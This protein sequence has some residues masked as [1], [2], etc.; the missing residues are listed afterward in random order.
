MRYEYTT[1]LTCEEMADLVARVRDLVPARSARCRP[2]A[3]GLFK[4]VAVVLTLMRQ[5]LVQGVVAD[6]FHVSQPTV[7]RI[8]RSMRGYL[9][10]ALEGTGISLAQ[11]VASR[12]LLVDG[13]YVRTGN[14]RASGKELYSGKRGCQCVSVQ[15]ACDL[16]GRLIT[17][18]APVPGVRHDRRAL[19]LVRW[20]QILDSGTWIADAGYVGTSAIT[21]I[22]KKPGGDLSADQVVFNH[23]ISRM[24][25][26]VERCIAHLK[27]WKMMKTG[28]RGRLA[29][30]PAAITLATKLELFRLGW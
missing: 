25:C 4:Q 2:P 1:G 11:A 3:L 28:Y 16:S 27:N 20:E 17:T 19:E 8:W 26:V 12:P 13:T 24:R 15:V 7:S 22:K 30:L 6:M 29:D 21:P 14:R 23:D 9:L 5:N 10:V 18:S